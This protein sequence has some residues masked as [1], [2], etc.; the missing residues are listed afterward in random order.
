M[1]IQPTVHPFRNLSHPPSKFVSTK[2]GPRQEEGVKLSR[3]ISRKNFKRET[4]T[5]LGVGLSHQVVVPPGFLHG[6][7]V[8]RTL[9]GDHTMYIAPRSLF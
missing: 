9:A 8:S 1:F 6:I 5:G 4:A 2:H 7:K 3:K